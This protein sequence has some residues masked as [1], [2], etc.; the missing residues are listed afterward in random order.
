MHTMNKITSIALLLAACCLVH[1][2][3]DREAEAQRARDEAEAKARAEAT[4]KE[5]EAAPKV[6]K[7]RDY[8]KRV[9]DTAP[10]SEAPVTKQ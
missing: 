3:T 5:M 4:R 9:D 2:C 10:A 1:G 8:L 6:F 7:N